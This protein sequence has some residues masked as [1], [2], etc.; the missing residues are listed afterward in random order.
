MSTATETT[1][2]PAAVPAT[3]ASQLYVN[4]PVKD[5][6][7]SIAFF[8]ALGFSFNPDFC[9]STAACLIL[10]PNLYAML[11]THETFKRFAPREIADSTKVCEALVALHLES[12]EKV[13]DIVRRAIAA[14]GAT[15]DEPTDHGF[16]YDHGFTD[17]DGHG[18]GVFW[19]NGTPAK[20]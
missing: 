15:H 14:G 3:T 11:L 13:D 8:K 20:A 4:L 17:L 12:R 5:L 19:M 9:D 2:A 1:A 10:G 16:M 6:D 18:W 7:A